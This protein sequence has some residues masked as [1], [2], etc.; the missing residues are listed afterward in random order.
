MYLPKRKK[1]TIAIDVSLQ[2]AQQRQYVFQKRV[3]KKKSKL[4]AKCKQINGLY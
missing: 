4:H 2:S 3:N 1:T